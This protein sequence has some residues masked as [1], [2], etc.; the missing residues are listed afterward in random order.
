MC[1]SVV[2]ICGFNTTREKTEQLLSHKPVGT[3]LIRPSTTMEATL[4]ISVVTPE[5]V[6]H[7]AID[8]HQPMDRTL[9]VSPFPSWTTV[10]EPL[11]LA[12]PV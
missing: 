6:T 5:R 2:Y 7:L 1:P 9:E 8:Y 4:V 12:F 3:F 10:S 11:L